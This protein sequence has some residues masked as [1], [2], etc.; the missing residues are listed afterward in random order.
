MR[1]FLVQRY[2]EFILLK[3]TLTPGNLALWLTPF[4]LILLGGGYLWIKA[5]Q[6]AIEAG[7]LTEDEQRALEAMGA[8]DQDMVSPHVGLTNVDGTAAIKH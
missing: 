8:E 3:P 6:P 5:R 2:G 4:A 1:D 7:G